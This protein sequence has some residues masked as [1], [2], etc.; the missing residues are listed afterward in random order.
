MSST[1]AAGYA[2]EGDVRLVDSAITDAG[3]TG[4][5]EIFFEGSW[6]QICASFFNDVDASVACRQLGFESG[7]N[8]P[9]RAPATTVYPEV[10]LS[11][12]ECNGTETTL[13]E[14]GSA[15]AAFPRFDGRFCWNEVSGP[16]TVNCVPQ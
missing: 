12:A 5:L 6:S 15:T 11:G 3:E 7:T 1:S 8:A 16:L 10:A 14:C 4:R 13:L 2:E 9:A